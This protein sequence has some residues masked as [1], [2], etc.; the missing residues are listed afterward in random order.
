MKPKES[1]GYT[2]PIVYKAFSILEEVASAQSQFGISD[3]S[4]QL[5]INKSTVFG[6]T[7]ALLDLGMLQQ[8]D[9][10]KKFRLGPALIKLGSRS[11]AGVSLST[12]ALP[13]MEKL[14]R[15]FGETVFLGRWD[16]SSITV[17]K[18][19]DS[20][21]ELKISA[22]EGTRI[23]FFAGASGKAFLA[24][25][26]AD[27]RSRFLQQ[28]KPRKF[29]ANSITDEQKYLAELERVRQAGYAMDFEEYMSGVNAIS[30]PVFDQRG[31]LAAAIWIVGFS[32]SF[33]QEKMHKAAAAA[34]V[35]SEEITFL[36]G[37]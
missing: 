20:Q 22:P 5:N 13:F 6:I 4:R 1:S 18:T 25:M 27:N 16:E 35:A 26:D 2:A 23:P 9:T 10:S 12:V 14:C 3:L 7:Q 36:L 21:S 33:N 29:T 34:K 37:G 11:L 30:V 24:F 31:L 17:I 15:E 8:D 32:S 28:R 19:V